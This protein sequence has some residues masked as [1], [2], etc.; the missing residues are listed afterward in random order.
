MSILQY[1]HQEYRVSFPWN[2]GTASPSAKLANC[3][4]D[5]MKW[6]KMAHWP[7]GHNSNKVSKNT[8]EDFPQVLKCEWSGYHVA[9]TCAKGLEPCMEET[10]VFTIKTPASEPNSATYR[11]GT[12]AGPFTSPASGTSSINPGQ[13]YLPHRGKRVK[14]NSLMETFWNLA[15]PSTLQT[16]PIHP[17]PMLNMWDFKSIKTHWVHG[18]SQRQN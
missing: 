11:S 2:E 10:P 17:F 18:V 5:T 4:P 16:F 3:I 13:Q 12:L 1:L 7:E 14:Y 9:C 6:N 15:C 8:Q